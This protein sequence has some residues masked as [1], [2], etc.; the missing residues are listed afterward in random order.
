LKKLGATIEATDDGMIIQ[1]PTELSGGTLVSY[2]DHRL[3][4]MA[5]IAAL[6]AS[7][8]IHIEDPACIAV[9]YPGFFKDLE[10]LTVSINAKG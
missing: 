1:G 4:M 9:S 8:P 10:K 6:I 2:G 3:G 7:A 5:G